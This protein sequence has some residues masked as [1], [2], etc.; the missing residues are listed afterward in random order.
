MDTNERGLAREQLPITCELSEAGQR[1]RR[2]ELSS[3]LFAGCEAVHELGDGYELVFPGS[4]EWIERLA[5]FVTAERQCCRFFEFE[6]LFAPDLGP[7]SLK[8][9]GPEG[10]KDFL[11]EYF[12]RDLAGKL[13]VREAL[14]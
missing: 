4:G 11:S 6:I 9:R 8:M 1:S 3:N 10:T 7:V 2:E 12:A 13:S 14:S 5:R